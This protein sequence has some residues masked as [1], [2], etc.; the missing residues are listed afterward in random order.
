MVLMD[1]LRFCM[2]Q[3]QSQA[4]NAK[5]AW[6]NQAFALQLPVDPQYPERHPSGKIGYFCQDSGWLVTGEQ[7][8]DAL[9]TDS[10]G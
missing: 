2:V 9:L 4:K 6:L 1:T 3:N 5:S 7:L 8:V 10:T